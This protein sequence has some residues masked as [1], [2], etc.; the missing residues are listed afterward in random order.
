LISNRKSNYLFMAQL[1]Q[2]QRS[3]MQLHTHPTFL[4]LL[5][6]F[7][8][9]AIA[10]SFPQPIDNHPLRTYESHPTPLPQPPQKRNFPLRIKNLPDGYTGSF[11]TFVSIAP[12]LPCTASF[13]HFFQTAATLAVTDP[14]PGR[15]RQR[16]T[17]G[18]LALELVA[19]GTDELVSREFVQATSLWLMDAATKGWAG[20]FR[21]W[22]VDQVDGQ[23]VEVRMGT[24]W[25]MLADDGV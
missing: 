12:K 13:I 18:G 20:F 9:A 15:R 17:L 3:D 5:L 8:A 10:I 21:A 22:V 14:S 6:Y 7:T 23:V 1:A 19:W 2:T 24:V 11:V 25:D 4:A 16:F